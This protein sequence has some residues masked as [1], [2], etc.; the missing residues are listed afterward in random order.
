MYGITETTIH[1][2]YK[3]IED[4]DVSYNTSNIGKALPHLRVHLLDEN[5]R[6]IS[7]GEVG[8][9]VV[10]GTGVARG[11]INKPELTNEKFILCSSIS[12]S[13]LY[14]SGDLGK[15]LEN[16]DIG[17]VGRVDNQ[18]KIRGHRIEL[19]EIEAHLNQFDGIKRAII[20]VV[21]TSETDKILKAFYTSNYDIDVESILDFLALRL[22]QYMI[23]VMLVRIEDFLKTA[24][25]KIDRKRVFEC[26]E[27]KSEKTAS[28][29]GQSNELTDIQTKILEVIFSSFE[30]TV[31]NQ[32]SLDDRFSDIG[33]D[34]ITF[35]KMII[36][37]ENEFEFEFDDEM[38]TIRKY[39][40]IRTM[41]E[42]VESKIKNTG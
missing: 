7:E 27:L 16:G 26:V 15:Y 24:N 5:Y 13:R 39:P 10:S 31:T 28:Q 29:G 25:G 32:T 3:E 19:E 8:E 20:A 23:P 11:Y 22:P 9:I 35:I 4:A 37:I 34:S 42:Y 30:D 12:E 18:V 33:L 2:T 14:R 40:F 38:L 21:E 6:P 1:V 41:V 17:Y 36:D